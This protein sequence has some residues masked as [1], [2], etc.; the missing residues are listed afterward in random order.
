MQVKHVSI[1][2]ATSKNIISIMDNI[3]NIILFIPKNSV[4][5]TEVVFG[6]FSMGAEAKEKTTIFEEKDYEN[7]K[8]ALRGITK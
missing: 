6:T 2:F 3:D 5:H 7:P 1:I 4:P 8:E